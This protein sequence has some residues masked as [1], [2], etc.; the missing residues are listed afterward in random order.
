MSIAGTPP[1]PPDR[2]FGLF[3]GAVF[4][5]IA[6]YGYFKGWQQLAVIAWAAGAGAFGVVALVAPGILRPLNKAWFWLGLLLGKIVS[7]IV[8]GIIFYGLLT[9]VGV[10]GRLLGRDELRLKRRSASS[11]WIERRPPG[12]ASDSFKNQF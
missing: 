5:A 12:P 8:L 10:A 2:R 9:P 3:F 7:P 1:L 6:A 11:Y 4:L